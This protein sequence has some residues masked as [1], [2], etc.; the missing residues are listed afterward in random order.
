MHIAKNFFRLILCLG[1]IQPVLAMETSTKPN[2]QKNL[3]LVNSTKILLVSSTLSAFNAA[4]D[5]RLNL[6]KTCGDLGFFANWNTQTCV[7]Y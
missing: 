1:L 5:P 2:L 7:R 3:D 4:L 6:I